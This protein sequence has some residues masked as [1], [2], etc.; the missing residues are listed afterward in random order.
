MPSI[1]GRILNYLL[2]PLYTRVFDQAEYGIVIV[3][4]GMVGFTFAILTYGMETSFFRYAE[5]TGERKKVFNTSA[6]SLLI[7]TILF[8]TGVLFFSQSIANWI[9]YPN[10]QDFVILMALIIG[11]DTLTAIPFALLR[12]ENRPGRFARIK[13]IN[14]ATNIGLNLIF[15]LLCPFVLKNFGNSSIAEFISVFYKPE[16]GIIVYVFISNLVA[17]ALTL[18]L[19]LPEFRSFNFRFDYAL[20]KKMI[21]YA[22]PLLFTG[23]AAIMNELF[24]RVAMKYILPEDIAEQQIGIYS[25]SYKIAILMSL[26]IQAFRYAAEPF[27]FAQ[28]KEKDAKNSY[29]LVMKYFVITISLVFLGIMM[30]L[31]VILLMLGENFREGAAVIPF[32]LIAY[33][34]LGIFYNLSIWY[35]LTNK[36]LYGAILALCGAG[37]TIIFNFLWIPKY[38]YMGSAYATLLCYGSMMIASYLIGLKHYK[39]NY[40]LK[41]II[42]YIG[43]SIFLYVGSTFLTLDNLILKLFIHTIFVA[44]FL[45]VVYLI[46]RRNFKA[47]ISR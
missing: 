12:A 5:L 26:F 19:L 27:F 40:D 42:S 20:W 32:L 9:E 34:C 21:V 35:K 10:H 7:T 1:I 41:R 17:S 28:A 8:L 14:I 31:D 4:Y 23:L 38:G 37:V 45:S 47:E 22:L 33:I 24:G 2:V 43:F 18:L 15:F 13:M 36:T 44:A 30:Y 11:F 39:V 25:A 29:A 16:N 46:E 6:F 3:L